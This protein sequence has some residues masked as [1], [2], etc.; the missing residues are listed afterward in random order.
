M[1]QVILVGR[2]TETPELKIYDDN[3]KCLSYF[4]LA[5]TRPY[6]DENGEYNT[7]FIR[8]VVWNSIANNVCDYCKKG[9]MIGV[10]GRLQS[11]NYDDSDGIKKYGFEVIAERI[12]FISPKK[13]EN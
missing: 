8:C 7:D 3:Q 2:L 10:K 6:K 9:D 11:Y 4:N 13:C 5:I 1:N 12:T